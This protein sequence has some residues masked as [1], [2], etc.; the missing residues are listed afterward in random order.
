M[1]GRGRGS[2]VPRGGKSSGRSGS[3]K[4]AGLVY[5][6]K[7]P[8]EDPYRDL[9]IPEDEPRDPDSDEYIWPEYEDEDEDRD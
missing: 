2:A 8:E 9:R 7:N 3:A 1:A 4:K 5:D 6:P